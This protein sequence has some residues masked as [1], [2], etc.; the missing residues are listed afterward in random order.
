MNANTAF[1]I[2]AEAFRIMTG[3]MAPGKDAGVM[4]G[5]DHSYEYRCQRWGDWNGLHGEVI[6][7][8]LKAVDNVLRL[9]EA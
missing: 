1:E 9:D 4:A 7:S 6:N 5:I 2:K 3:Y 8:M